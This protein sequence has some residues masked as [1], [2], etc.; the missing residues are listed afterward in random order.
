V[1]GISKQGKT[2]AVTKLFA[3]CYVPSKYWFLQE[4]HSATSQKWHS[5]NENKLY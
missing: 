3:S 2:L 4:P 1:E 5:S